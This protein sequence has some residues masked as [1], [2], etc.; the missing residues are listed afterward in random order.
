MI[1]LKNVD[2]NE[3]KKELARR[4]FR[5]FIK[6]TKPNYVFSW[7]HLLVAHKLNE[8]AHGRIKRLMLFEPPRHGKSEQASRRLPAFIFGIRPDAQV[9]GTSYAADLAEAMSR[10]V[11]KIIMDNPYKELFPDTRLASKGVP[12][13]TGAKYINTDERWEIVDRAGSY[14]SAGVTGGITGMGADFLLIDDPIKDWREARSAT[15]RQSIW[16]WYVSTAQTRLQEGAGV[17]VIQTRWNEDDLSG[18]LLELAAKDPTADQWD[19]V[20][21]PAILEEPADNDYDPREIG[22]ALWPEFKPVNE[23]MKIK[24]SS[25]ETW[26]AL[27]QQTPSPASGNLVKK[28]TFKYYD[29][30]S[31]N[32]ADF[33]PVVSVDASFKG[34]KTSDFVVI[35][36]WGKIGPDHFLIDQVRDKMGFS[37]TL[38]ALKKIALRFPNCLCWLIEEAANGAAIIDVLKGGLSGVVPVRP[39]ESKEARLEAVIPLFE[40]GNV[41]LPEG[42]PWLAAYERELLSFPKAKNDDQVDAT[43]QYLARHSIDASYDLEALLKL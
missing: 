43:S 39:R 15:V 7:S 22:E 19:V 34:N 21:L 5:H 11:K 4:K 3:V 26:S 35:Q 25:I 16:D 14:R 18:R 33:F 41:Y 28:E 2:P 6:Y 13:K 30:G 31:L 24:A 37:D 23:L 32:S 29:Y 8:F 1:D 17:L 38:K 12:S 36:I 10:D 9:I 40:S 27:Y 20:S 42:A